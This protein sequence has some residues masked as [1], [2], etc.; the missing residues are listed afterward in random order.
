MRSSPGPW[1]PLGFRGARWVA[2]VLAGIWLGSL[3][4]GRAQAWIYPEHRDITVLALDGL[5]AER[6]AT[7][8]ALWAEARAGHE[9][10]LCAPVVDTTQGTKPSCFDW[11]AWP[12]IAGDHS[13]SGAELV[14]TIIDAAWSLDVAAIGAELKRDLAGA[15]SRANRINDLRRS[16]LKLQRSDLRYAT[17]AGS[18]NV[19]F[20]LA[21]PNASI[22]HTEYLRLCLVE[23]SEPS[24]IGAYAWYH[25][26]ALMKASRLHGEAEDNRA[27][28]VA[29]ARA[30]LADEAFAIHFLEDAFSAGHV[31]GTW[32]SAAV[33]KGT[34]DYYNERGLDAPTWNRGE[35][36]LAG[37]AHMRPEDAE[38]AAKIVRTSIEQIADASRGRVN[39]PS[40]AAAEVSSPDAL[41]VCGMKGIPSRP[42]SP[43]AR[44]LELAIADELPV[45]ALGDG[46]GAVPRFRAELGPFIGISAAAGASFISGGFSA[47]ETTGGAIGVLDV[48]LRLGLGLEGVMGESGDG[49]VFLDLGLRHD[50]ASSMSFSDNPTLVETGAITAAIPARFRPHPPRARA[51]LAGA[52]RPGARGSGGGAAFAA[53]FHGD[54]G[55][56]QQ[57]WSRAVASG[58][59]DGDRP[60]S[61]RRRSGGR[62]FL[63]RVPWRRGPNAHAASRGR[64]DRPAGRAALD[65]VRLSAGRVSTLP[66]VLAGS[67]IDA[68]VPDRRRIPDQRRSFSDRSH[69]RSTTRPGTT[70]IRSGSG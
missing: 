16:D 53:P 17:R 62:Y 55:R 13:C 38:R 9:G 42:A 27:E 22:D 57:R 40:D 20:L 32:G 59:R 44:P 39:V 18:N 49:L 23:G 65:R 21:R 29:L 41:D 24:A 33:R 6:R 43:A 56:G 15:K 66:V 68:G 50:T 35:H 36:V 19:H 11:A 31:A 37:D 4:A 7:I 12:A 28:R 8:D 1:L 48:G 64:R 46:L 60:L 30:V 45:P 61:I 25:T 26:S 51:F 58:D 52:R 54:G 14:S 10:R 2:S 69:G 67:G 47:G 34:H 63:L 3:P 70:S 5:N